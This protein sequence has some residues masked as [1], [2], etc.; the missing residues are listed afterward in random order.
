MFI[1]ARSL[2][3]GRVFQSDVCIIGAGAAGIALATPLTNAGLRVDLIESGGFESELDTQSLT[4]AK[5][6]GF[7]GL[8]NTMR[9]PD[10]DCV[11]TSIS[12]SRRSR[13]IFRRRRLF[14][15]D[16]KSSSSR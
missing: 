6:D 5:G 4:L 12:K 9:L 1:D 3:D 14:S 10:T 16:E 15:S 8:M 11:A 7:P 13:R 2:E